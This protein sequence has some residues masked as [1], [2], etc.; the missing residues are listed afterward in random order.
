[1]YIKDEEEVDE[2]SGQSRYE[3]HGAKIYK[4]KQLG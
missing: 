1:M 3:R 2:T 4:K